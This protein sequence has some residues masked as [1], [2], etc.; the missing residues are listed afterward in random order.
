[1][2]FTES[3]LF[4]DSLEFGCRG[5]GTFLWLLKLGRGRWAFCGAWGHGRGCPVVLHA[6]Q[7][8]PSIW[9]PCGGVGVIWG[10]ASG[11][12]ALTSV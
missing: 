1:M 10:L 11:T 6:W 9:G 2:F 12:S 3:A 5:P 7:L 4:A 8:H